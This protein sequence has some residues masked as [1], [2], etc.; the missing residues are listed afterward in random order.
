MHVLHLD[1]STL[2]RGLA[3]YHG[4]ALNDPRSSVRLVHNI[5]DSGLMSDIQFAISDGGAR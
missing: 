2:P 5:F 1:A 4:F 3:P